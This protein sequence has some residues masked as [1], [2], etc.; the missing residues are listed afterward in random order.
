MGNGQ[1]KVMNFIWWK[2]FRKKTVESHLGGV[3][4][5]MQPAFLPFCWYYNSQ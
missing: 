1:N 5:Y 2:M 4:F 3:D